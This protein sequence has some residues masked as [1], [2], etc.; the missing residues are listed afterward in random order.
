ME[1]LW[2]Q[3][4][5]TD[6]YIYG[7]EP[8]DWFVEKL[9]IL[10][11]GKI[12]LP[13][14]G[15]GR[16][17]AWAAAQGWQVTAFDQSPEAKTKAMR[18][19]ADKNVEFNYLVKDLRCF[20]GEESTFDAIGLIYVHMPSDFRLQVH[21]ELLRLLKPGGCIILEAFS[22]TQMENTSG[23]PKNADLLYD[24]EDLKIDFM[25][26]RM[27]E[28]HTIRLHLEEGKLHH[29]IADVIRLFGRKR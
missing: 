16:N 4:Y 15:E 19:A 29:G 13:A 22:K 5:A 8:N 26:L 12:L 10:K 14:E 25:Q 9:K 1:N 18:L 27:L 11:P 2:D 7:T 3:R 20:R 28:F 24:A 23:G 6:D 21:T 17:A